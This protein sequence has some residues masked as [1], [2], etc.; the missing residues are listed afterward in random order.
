MLARSQF[1]FGWTPRCPDKPPV[2]SSETWTQGIPNSS[3]L[4][5]TPQLT[6]ADAHLVVGTSHKQG[7][8]KLNMQHP[9]EETQQIDP[10]KASSIG[11]NKN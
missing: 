5:N 1:A 8:K 11:D 10:A 9:L 7:G 2:I 3:I 6:T 4:V